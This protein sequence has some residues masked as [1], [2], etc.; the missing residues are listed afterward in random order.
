MGISYKKPAAPAPAQ[1]WYA[2][3]NRKAWSDEPELHQLDP[4]SQQA[5]SNAQVD[6]WNQHPDQRLQNDLGDP[7]GQGMQRRIQQ[8]QQAF[9]FG[10]GGTSGGGG[11]GFLPPSGGGGTGVAGGPMNYMTSG[12]DVSQTFNRIPGVDA[13]DMTQANAQI[14]GR[15]KD[16]AGQMG[17]ASLQSLRDELGATGM[18]GSGSEAQSTQNIIAHGAG[19][20][21]EVSRENAV[22]ESAQKADFAK[23]KYQGDIT[24]RGQDIAAQ[25]AQAR[26]ALQREMARQQMLLEALRNMGG[27][28]YGGYGGGSPSGGGSGGQGP[29]WRGPGV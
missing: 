9:G 7:E 6:Y 20:L 22:N 14:F 12:E 27:G 26:L 28:G 11:G 2:Q 10:G 13:P 4:N 17:R 8:L 23:M 19:Q 16:Q 15:A 24:Q 25:E 1:D 29:I 21:G 18:L 5:R 3:N